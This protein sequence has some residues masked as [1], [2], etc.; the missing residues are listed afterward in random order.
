MADNEKTKAQIKQE[1]LNKKYI[2][3]AKNEWANKKTIFGQRY[4]FF[5]SLAETNPSLYN[6][7]IS[8]FNQLNFNKNLTNKNTSEKIQQFISYQLLLEDLANK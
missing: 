6:N 1:K 7:A 4:V 5:S 3:E 2:K 8:Y